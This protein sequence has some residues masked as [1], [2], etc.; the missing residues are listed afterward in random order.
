MHS[1]GN[2][3]TIEDIDVTERT[4][5]VRVDFN[6]PFHP[7]RTEIS[8]DSRI[9]ASLPTLR[10]LLERRCKLVI[11]SHLGRPEG[12]VITDLSM[13]PITRRLSQLLGAP[14]TQAPRCIGPDVEQAVAILRALQ[15]LTGQQA[16]EQPYIFVGT[17][18]NGRPM[19][20]NTLAVAMRT[21]GVAQGT[22][23]IHGW[24]AAAR[25]CLDEQLHFPPPVIEHQLA[26]RVADSL[27]AAYNRTQHLPERKKMMQEWA[28]YLDDIYTTGE[29]VEFRR[30][31][32]A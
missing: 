14:V 17:R 7:G 6:V 32:D 9:K 31:E 11:C 2:K 19:S 25:T 3:K 5:L 28:D 21:M 20:E 1:L 26:H 29:V 22:H 13:A 10:Y 4:I 27:G 18:N 16:D 8:D 23:T 12:R 24:R 15:P 30:A